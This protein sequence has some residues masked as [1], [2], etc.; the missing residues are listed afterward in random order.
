MKEA[1]A[2]LAQPSGDEAQL[3]EDNSPKLSQETTPGT[4]QQ[5]PKTASLLPWFLLIGVITL[6]SSGSQAYRKEGL[7]RQTHRPT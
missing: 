2:T 1:P 3:S 4:A 7:M 5:L 6:I